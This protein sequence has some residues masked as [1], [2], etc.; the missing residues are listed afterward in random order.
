VCTR[1]FP[2]KEIYTKT[3]T[4]IITITITITTSITVS[5]AMTITITGVKQE[6]ACSRSPKHCIPD[7]F[8]ETY[9]DKVLEMVIYDNDGRDDC[10]KDNYDNDDWCR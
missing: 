5:I 10:G 9:R 1:T 4:I 8:I 6:S 7:A 3:L 2:Q